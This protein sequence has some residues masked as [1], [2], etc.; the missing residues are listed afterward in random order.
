ME[1]V[2][3][4]SIQEQ[5]KVAMDGRTQ[6]WLALNAK[7]PETDLS[8]K[9]AD[10]SNF[11]PAFNAHVMTADAEMNQACCQF[12][13]NF[14]YIGCAVLMPDA[15]FFLGGEHIFFAKFFQLQINAIK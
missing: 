9:L 14:F 7:I 11:I 13:N 8:K 10:D 1:E 2:K 12:I 5:I 3:T 4:L 15:A 6:R